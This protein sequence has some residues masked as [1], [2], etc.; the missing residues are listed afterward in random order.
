MLRVVFTVVIISLAV[1]LTVTTPALADWQDDLRELAAADDAGERDALLDAVIAAGPSCDEVVEVL[2]GLKFPRGTTGTCVLREHECLDG[3]VRPWVL[4]IPADYDPAEPAPLFVYLHGGV[5]RTELRDDPMDYARENYINPLADE[6]GML[7]IY[8]FGQDGATWWDE[9]GMAGIQDALR[10]VKREYNVDDDRV[11]MGG[12]SD[13]SSG[14][15][16]H[17]MVRPSDYAGFIALNGHMGVGSL[18]GDLPTYANNMAITPVYAVTTFDDQLYPSER[19]RPTIAMAM[20]AGAL[21]SYRELPGTH[22]F[23]YAGTELPLIARFIERCR[24]DP[25]CPVIS[26][27]AATRDFGRC[28]WFRI[29]NVGMGEAAPWHTDHNAIL[30]DD[31]ITLGFNHDDGFEGPGILVGNVV[32]GTAAAR[33]GLRA[34]DV[35]VGAGELPIAGMADLYTFKETLARG[36]G[37]S[38]TVLRDGAEQVLDGELPPVENYNLFK[39]DRPSARVEVR[40]LGNRVEVMAS[41]LAG[42]TVYVHPDMFDLAEPVVITVNGEEVYNRRVKPDVEYL[43]KNYLKRRDRK[44]LYIAEISVEL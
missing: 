4:R 32:E 5:G 8:P 21:I 26:W 29:D 19:M 9:V 14:S 10:T 7:V 18:D 37:F 25:V 31:R 16:C 43:L 17:A 36:A 2:A 13:G 39:R 22:E 12:F 33:C 35:I 44:A 3:V 30:A 34:D 6:L 24:R 38:L 28:Q 15:F 27:E 40:R 41:R 42:F 23:D 20:D 11:F 1:C